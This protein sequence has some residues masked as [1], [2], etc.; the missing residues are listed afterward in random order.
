MRRS[1]IACTALLLL[2]ACNSPTDAGVGAPMAIEVVSG[3]N[4]TRLAG[5]VLAEPIVVRV[6]D[7]EGR[8][9][10][11]IEIAPSTTAL[12][13][14]IDPAQETTTNEMGEATIRWRLGVT[15]GAQGLRVWLPG[16][17]SVSGTTISASATG[18]AVRAIV[19]TS[20][21]HCAAYLDGRIGCWDIVRPTEAAPVPVVA[22]GPLR[23]TSLAVASNWRYEGHL[24]LCAPATTGRVWCSEFDDRTDDFTPWREIP[25]DYATLS[26]LVGSPSGDEA[27]P[28]VFCGLD[29]EG[30]VWC[31]GGNALGLL[32]DG[33]TVSRAD[34]RPVAR[35]SR[36]VSL[37]GGEGH[38]C[39]QDADE[40]VWCWG[41]NSYG[42]LG[43]P[44][45]A[46]PQPVPLPVTTSRSLTQ[47][48]AVDQSTCAVT[49]TSKLV[50]WGKAVPLG[51]PA[52]LPAGMTDTAT[53][54]EVSGLGPATRYAFASGAA[55]V[56]D[57]GGVGHW[58]GDLIAVHGFSPTPVPTVG[59]IPFTELLGHQ[60]GYHLC[61]RLSVE[62]GVSCIV[63]W[64]LALNG[65]GPLD[66]GFGRLFGMGVP[67]AP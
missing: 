17:A 50:C 4:Q 54:T 64:E 58:W 19:T 16:A 15:V 35:D 14:M 57:E 20:E 11:G 7:A 26:D 12:G 33:T 29:P 34:A 24:A 8:E 55:F 10:P 13:G 47:P 51:G 37:T 62:G 27:M 23:F 3:N 48:R 56:F 42:Q 5:L 21:R 45:T 30:T 66:S 25:G 31:W 41:W 65:V 2:A 61:G 52:V 6:V 38:F 49:S 18:A 43:R 1:A 39:G 63:P 60:R 67:E 59:R 53:P 44:R 32:G 22:Q 28:E 46:E 9:V 36:F 40:V